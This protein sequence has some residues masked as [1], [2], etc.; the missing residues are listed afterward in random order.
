MLHPPGESCTTVGL[1]GGVDGAG[2]LLL[3]P[4]SSVATGV[5][6]LRV[7]VVDEVLSESGSR[8]GCGSRREVLVGVAAARLSNSSWIAL[9]VASLNFSKRRRRR[10]L[11]PGVHR[12]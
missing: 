8:G 1:R 3:T 10:R 5:V 11:A 2:A 9:V 12:S 4:S 6:A 7:V